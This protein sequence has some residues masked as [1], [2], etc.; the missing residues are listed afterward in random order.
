MY[1]KY[2]FKH[3]NMKSIFKVE[4][5]K[6]ETTFE[7][8]INEIKADHMKIITS[9]DMDLSAITLNKP[10]SSSEDLNAYLMPW[11]IL[12]ATEKSPQFTNHMSYLNLEGTNQLQI[13]KWWVDI[14]S[15]LYLYLFW[16]D[17]CQYL[18][19]NISILLT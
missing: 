15:G 17:F 12:K 7:K 8:K 19:T 6:P 4:K 5:F 10:S 16:S 18:S 13:R 11:I 2:Q 3:I 1:F 9:L 14:R